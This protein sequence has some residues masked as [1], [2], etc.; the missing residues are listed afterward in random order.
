M[1]GWAAD[2][3]GRCRHFY[4]RSMLQI[5]ELVSRQV[6]CNCVTKR[7]KVGQEGS[8]GERERNAP[9]L[10]K[11]EAIC[12]R[13][14]FNL[15]CPTWPAREDEPVFVAVVVEDVVANW[16]NNFP[17]F[18]C[19]AMRQVAGNAWRQHITSCARPRPGTGA[20]STCPLCALICR[21]CSFCLGC[22]R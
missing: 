14:A 8:E 2:Y 15:R 13:V 21:Q 22:A 9:R 20:W 1:L 18:D 7:R 6:R 3:L 10:A 19:R 17:L 4:G 11:C 5:V 12:R 16:S